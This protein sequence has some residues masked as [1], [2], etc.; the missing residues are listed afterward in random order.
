MTQLKF[1]SLIGNLRDKLSTIDPELEKNLDQLLSSTF[2]IL[3]SFLTNELTA[4]QRQIWLTLAQFYPDPKSGS[5][6]ATITGSS[7]ASKSIY[8]S[9]DVLKRK[10]LITVHQP[11]PRTF[12]IQA[13]P[14]HPLTEILIDFCSYYGTRD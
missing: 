6:L 12:S 13:N 3:L 10:Q 14:S 5:E 4:Q 9:I 2:G 8:K 1:N 7:K 11:H